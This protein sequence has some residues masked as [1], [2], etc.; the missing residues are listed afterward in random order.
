ML[1]EQEERR[2][3][4]I[5][6]ESEGRE[7]RIDMMWEKKRIIKVK[8]KTSNRVYLNNYCKK[9]VHIYIYTRTKVGSFWAK[10]M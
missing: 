6:K 1:V 4:E 7:E 8:C 5:E 9:S 3:R 10:K 2:E